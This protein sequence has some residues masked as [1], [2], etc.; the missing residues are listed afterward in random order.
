MQ[1]HRVLASLYSDEAIHPTGT[2]KNRRM[3]EAILQRLGEIGYSPLVQETFACNELGSC[4]HVENILARLEGS[5]GGPAVLLA[6]HYDSVG[7]GPSVSDDGVAVAISLE[8]ARMLRARSALRNDVIFLI[9]DGEE[10]GLLGAVAFTEQHPWAAEVG[11]VVNLEARG[12]AGRSY[13]FETGSDNAWL[14]EL[15]AEHLVRP[16]T[17]SLFDS[18]YER[19][20]NDTDFTIFKAHGMNGV[21]FAF[22]Q[23]AVHYHTPLDDLAHVTLS[24]LQHHGDNAWSMVRALASTD[25]DSPPAGNATWF[26]VWGFGILS[27]PERWNGVLALLGLVLVAIAGSVGEARQELTL[28]RICWGVLVW[29][30][31]VLGTAGLAVAGAWSLRALAG[32]PAWPATAWAP[33]AAFWLLGLSV[34]ALV[35]RWLGRQAGPSATWLGALLWLSLLSLAVSAALPGATYLFLA[36]ALVGGL[37]TALTRASGSK[38]LGIVAAASTV[39]AACLVQGPLAWSLWDAMGI[40]IMPVVSWLIAGVVIL[41][42]AHAADSEYWMETKL[43]VLGMALAAASLSA[44][45]VLPPFSSESPQVLNLGHLQDADLR[46]AKWTATTASRALPEP[47]RQAVSWREA[48]ETP[49]PWSPRLDRSWLAQAPAVPSPSPQMV[50]LSEEQIDGGRL[51]RARFH[52][53]R[54]ADRGTVIFHDADRVAELRIEG[55]EVDLQG[56]LISRLDAENQRSVRLA[57]VPGDGI[58]LDLR[59]RGSE[60]LDLTLLDHTYGLP[61][62]GQD[63]L[64]SRPDWVVPGWVGNLTS[65]RK[66]TSL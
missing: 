53:P 4:A 24:S 37:L 16:A 39:A 29:P 65:V 30:V 43:P 57:T 62:V 63:L 46:T 33:K 47:L 48:A 61:E 6:V 55:R 32:L 40:S 59:I 28:S 54:G 34:P 49:L 38:T 60:P 31:A 50:L 3:K 36:P 15:M 41:V 7:S 1:A 12:T 21:N 51:L 23:N 45:M 58:E 42:L 56:D 2:A 18:I 8:I 9:D 20:P 44:A 10:V 17:S 52:S 26:D 19:L 66:R 13:M 35:I 27:W 22:I 64:E 11:A 14:V 5:G 25:L